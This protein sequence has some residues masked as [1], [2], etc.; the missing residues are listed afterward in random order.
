MTK[1]LDIYAI[2]E[3]YHIQSDTSETGIVYLKGNVYVG[4]TVKTYQERYQEHLHEAKVGLHDKDIWLR[5]ADNAE[6]KRLDRA[7]DLSFAY[8][9]E[10]E[11]IL[12]YYKRG[13]GIVNTKNPV[14]NQD[15][16]ACILKS[17]SLCY[18]R[19]EQYRTFY[20]YYDLGLKYCHAFSEW[21]RSYGDS[22]KEAGRF[23]ADFEASLRLVERMYQEFGI[24]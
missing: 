23:I 6:A 8:V 13:W 18:G 1:M 14:T 15:R 20:D 11:H 22:D 2:E 19:D 3:D 4:S 10:L 21:M 24:D 9:K 5:N 7:T 17:F 16:P 12:R